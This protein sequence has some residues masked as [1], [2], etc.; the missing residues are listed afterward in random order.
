MVYLS[1]SSENRDIHSVNCQPIAKIRSENNALNNKVI[2]LIND[3]LEIP[4]QK[5]VRN[6]VIK[7][8]DVNDLYADSDYDYE[9]ENPIFTAMQKRYG[10]PRIYQ[11]PKPKP[12]EKVNTR[13]EIILRGTGS[14]LEPLPSMVSS[15]NEY[16]EVVPE[17]TSVCYIAGARGSGKSTYCSIFAK[18][19]CKVFPNNNLWLFSTVLKDPLLDDL[20][21]QRVPL[22]SLVDIKAKPKPTPKVKPKSKGRGRPKKEQKDKEPE[23]EPESEHEYESEYES[24]SEYEPDWSDRRPVDPEISK[25]ILARYANSLVI[26]DDIDAILD[27]SISRA[28]YNLMYH[29]MHNGRTAGITMC[30]TNHIINEYT[31]TK[32]IS[33]NCSSITIF[34]QTVNQHNLIY[35]LTKY[36]GFSNE[37][38][39][40][41]LKINPRFFTYNKNYPQ[42]CF[43]E[44]GAYVFKKNF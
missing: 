44:Y 10:R 13:Q 27:K 3:Q 12:E 18:N 38:I 22:E 8:W 16:G 37:D 14:F 28:V 43:Y 31:K 42:C 23:S 30:I 29:M 5:K 26:F 20:G 21:F 33:E 4:G 1:F 9:D 6:K 19:Y 7:V 2:Y 24:E 36:F 15:I 32:P 11:E 35:C 41:I 39:R 40:K 17:Q 25:N 34:P